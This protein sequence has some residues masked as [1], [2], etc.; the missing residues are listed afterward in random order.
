LEI[1]EV[2]AEEEKERPAC[3]GGKIR[4]PPLLL[5]LLLLLLLVLVVKSLPLIPS[6]S[7][8]C[9]FRLL[10]LLLLLLLMLLMLLL[11]LLPIRPPN[12][13]QANAMVVKSSGRVGHGCVCLPFECGEGREGGRG[14][15]FS[16]RATLLSLHCH[17]M[18]ACLLA[19][20]ESKPDTH[21][22]RS[23][24]AT[25][26]HGAAP[27]NLWPLQTSLCLTSGH[28]NLQCNARQQCAGLSLLA[29][30]LGC[31]AL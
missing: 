7:K 21:H 1:G 13:R 31:E 12:P 23:Q 16:H 5:L 28:T 30:F 20:A 18:L 9:R 17:R 14:G 2:E 6:P 19:A 27:H 29:C 24:A 26:T 10:L 4:D 8:I 3:S 15:S 22:K 11:L 25:A